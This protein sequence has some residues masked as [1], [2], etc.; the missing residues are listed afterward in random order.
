MYLWDSN[1]LRAYLKG[2]PTVFEHTRRATGRQI[3][4]PSVVV[5]EALR[6]RSDSLLKA[7]PQQ[8]PL[9]ET[10]MREMIQTVQGFQHISFDDASLIALQQLLKQHQ[11]RKRY[12]DVM[13][14][15]LAKAGQHV[16]VT[17][18]TKD[19]A[20]LLPKVQL[21]NWIDDMPAR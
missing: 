20:D 18:N 4:L 21:Q 14:A 5:A 7:T 2:H 8:I 12:A 1:I 19:F 10:L 6:G 15:A 9:A 16:V 17:R 13:I 11:S 3:A